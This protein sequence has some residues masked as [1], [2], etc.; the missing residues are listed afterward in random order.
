M[1]DQEQNDQL[2]KKRRFTLKL[3][4]LLKEHIERD[5]T[6]QSW[7]GAPDKWPRDFKER[8]LKLAFYRRQ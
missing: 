1:S 8:V 7:I 5:Q 2:A 3:A 6:F 4:R